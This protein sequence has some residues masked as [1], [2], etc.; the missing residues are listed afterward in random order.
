M[1][2]RPSAF[3]AFDNV[4]GRKQPDPPPAEQTL[5]PERLSAG[6]ILGQALNSVKRAM[7]SSDAGDATLV[8]K[9]AEPPTPP[10]N[11]SAPAVIT[12]P[13]PPMSRIDT[14]GNHGAS[15]FL[16]DYN[17][18]VDPSHELVG[19]EKDIQRMGVVFTLD[20]AKNLLVWGR[21][22]IGK[23]E[24][25]KGL[26]A[27]S[28]RG[29]VSLDMLKRTFLRLEVETLLAEDD[30]TKI[31][32][33]MAE[34]VRVLE[35]RQYVVLTVD[36]AWNFVEGLKEKSASGAFN[37]LMSAIG[38]RKFQSL[39]IVDDEHRDDLIKSHPSFGE[40][41]TLH[42]LPEQDP[43][44]VLTTLRGKRD[45]YQKRYG[46]VMNDDGIRSVAELS[47][48]YPT[49]FAPRLGQPGRAVRLQE[50]T[51]ASYRYEFMT[52]PT[53]LVELEG[54]VQRLNLEKVALNG[55]DEDRKLQIEDEIAEDTPRYEVLRSAWNEKIAGVLDINE[56]KYQAILKLEKAQDD[57]AEAE[58]ARVAGEIHD[59][60]VIIEEKQKAIDGFNKQLRE[61]NIGEPSDHPLDQEKVYS[62][63][64]V[65]TGIPAQTLGQTEIE[66]ITNVEPNMKKRLIGQDDA[67]RKSST[68]LRNNA[69]GFASESRPIGAF[70]LIG[71]SGVG[72]SE[73]GYVLDEAVSGIPGSKPIV[74]D[75]GDFQESHTVATLL[76]APPGY[77]GGD[78]GGLLINDV[79]AKP[80]TVVMFDEIEK[81]HKDIFDILLPVL[82]KAAIRG[83]NGLEAKFN[84]TIILVTSNIGSEFFLDES[85]TFEQASELAMHELKFG[86]NK[87]RPEI[88]G[89]FND[90]IFFNRLAPEPQ[91]MIAKKFLS[92]RNSLIKPKGFSLDIADFDVRRIRDKFYDPAKGG[93][94]LRNVFEGP[95]S[96]VASDIILDERLKASKG[97][98]GA[99]IKNPPGG[100]IKIE[101]DD[102]GHFS[103]RF[104]PAE[105]RRKVFDVTKGLG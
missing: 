82:D 17:D 73:M 103:A 83:R 24:S 61:L 97:Q 96:S 67:V 47:H 46:I 71:P 1:A 48:K 74:Y 6:G 44:Q 25:V 40:L 45:Y 50:F 68:A 9:S 22:G 42:E 28:R 76:G 72:K 32:S 12:T 15:R 93:R 11:E 86:K 63:F 92:E 78:M 91:F 102:V 27:R 13:L 38:R 31:N 57:L 43:D 2:Q 29:E 100:E 58:S 19:M 10:K 26:V 64:S 79:R 7:T 16:T 20:E 35:R 18:L 55:S 59:C 49:K 75:M 70:F 3:D 41:F 36:N 87:V 66:R 77:S 81:A 104:R 52:K 23:S 94:S 30:V 56:K 37:T 95:I 80:F 101:M 5:A 62:I 98:Y 65:H 14:L 85:L 51:A 90:I 8:G 99:G 88:L 33:N 21:A 60:K 54:K 89:R 84:G 4:V 34:I 53:E 39:M 105:L 69:A